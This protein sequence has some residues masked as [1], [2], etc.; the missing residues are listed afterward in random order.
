VSTVTVVATPEPANLPPRVRLDV[1]DTGTSPA[2][3]ATTVT[4]LNPDGITSPVRTND[5]NPLSLTTSGSNR[6]GLLYDYEMAYGAP[7]QYSTMETPG[8]SSAQVT[9]SVSDIWLIHVG[10][11]ALSRP[12]IVS[13]WGERK[14]PVAR[15]VFHPMG[16]AAAVVQTSGVRQAAEYDLTVLTLTDADADALDDLIADAGTVLLNIPATKNINRPSEYVS[17]GDITQAGLT[18]LAA[19]PGRLW[20]LP[21]TVVDRPVGGSQAER[22]LLDLLDFPTLNDIRSAYTSLNAV[23]AG[24]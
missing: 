8:S 15:G 5:G 7:V 4:R 10:V 12:I 1:T 16:R 18:R 20:T 22:T 3:T 19:E 24:P 11:P 6:V 23:L 13:T 17:V 14:R 9:I 21:C 2:I